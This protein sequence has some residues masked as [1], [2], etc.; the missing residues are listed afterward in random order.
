MVDEL[1]IYEEPSPSHVIE[2]ILGELELEGIML[3]EAGEEV[4]QQGGE[5]VLEPITETVRR[6]HTWKPNMRKRFLK[7]SK[8]RGA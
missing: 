1:R 6:V 4:M 2:E 7:Y 5:E 3:E 8:S